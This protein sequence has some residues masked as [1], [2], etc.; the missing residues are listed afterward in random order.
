[1]LLIDVT[2]GR[3]VLDDF[4]VLWN[5]IKS[6]VRMEK[7]EIEWCA[8]IV[9]R[10][11]NSST[12]DQLRSMWDQL[13]YFL[14]ID[15]VNLREYGLR[16]DFLNSF[17]NFQVR[18]NVKYLNNHKWYNFF[19]ERVPFWLIFGSSLIGWLFLK[20]SRAKRLE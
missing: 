14:W 19:R 16:A 4:Y 17:W 9:F 3:L 6:I 5:A 8:D 13:E 7:F 12:H 18:L 20:K 15:L 10:V 2:A 11:Q 1:M